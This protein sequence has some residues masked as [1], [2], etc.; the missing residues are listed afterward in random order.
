MTAPPLVLAAHTLTGVMPGDPVVA[1]HDLGQRLAA[2]ADAGF[3]GM[4]LH[5]RDYARLRAKGCADEDLRSLYA[6]AGLS[7]P[8]IEFLA[9][10]HHPTHEAA[11]TRDLAFQA[12]RAMGAPVVTVGLDALDDAHDLAALVAPLRDLCARAEDAG[13][14]I[15]LEPVAWGQGRNLDDALE[16]IA[17]AGD[18]AGLLVDVWHLAWRDT[19]PEALRDVPP[20]KVLGVQIS[21][22]IAPGDAPATAV[23]AQTLNRKLCGTGDIDIASYLGV[24][25][26]CGW[27][28]PVAV[29]IMA[30]D[31]AACDVVKAARAAYDTASPFVISAWS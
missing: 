28:A 3:Q 27:Q 1:R 6:S 23:R 26:A 17:R 19:P 24:A 20:A 8:A 29:E 12:A 5:L 18:Q 22:S 15:A 10:W 9:D 4:C 13:L 30:P 21:D 2:A 25:A 11:A 16:V 14:A 31:F 7:V